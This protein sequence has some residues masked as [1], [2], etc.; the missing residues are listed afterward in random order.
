M[1]FLFLSVSGCVVSVVVIDVV[2]AA[3]AIVILWH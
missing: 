2:A 3:L 1:D